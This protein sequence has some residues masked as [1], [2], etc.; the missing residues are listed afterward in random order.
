MDTLTSIYVY[1]VKSL[2]GISLQESLVQARG[3]QYDRR[4]MLTDDDGRFVSQREVPEL[5]LLATAIEPP[6]LVIFP[7]QDPGHR[8]LIPLE[9][10]RTGK[11]TETVRIWDDECAAWIYPAETNIWFSALLNRSLRLVYIPDD[12]DRPVDPKYAPAGQQ[13]SFADGYPF[14]LIGQ[15]SLDDL[16]SR[17][18]QPLPMNRFRP[19]FVVSGSSPYAEDEWQD[20]RIGQVVF[21]GVKP[22]ARCIL[23]TTDQE[24]AQRGAEP[25]K[26]LST[27]RKSGNRILFGQNVIRTS[28]DDGIVRVG[29]PV[30]ILDPAGMR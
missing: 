30:E 25:L 17:M 23:T 6:N 15:A 5:A 11:T 4:W 19:N 2:A 26:T 10:E 29:D 3:L 27:Y 18:D 14:L 7:K 12:A 1:P 8:L 9:P 28:A 21:Q 22:C 16:N 24:T 20:F 13:V